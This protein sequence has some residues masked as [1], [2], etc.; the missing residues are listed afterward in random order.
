MSLHKSRCLHD[1]E[2][3]LSL[4][5]RRKAIRFAQNGETGWTDVGCLADR[6]VSPYTRA[7]LQADQ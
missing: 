6:C 4:D 5:R 2:E 1:L 3:T 7:E